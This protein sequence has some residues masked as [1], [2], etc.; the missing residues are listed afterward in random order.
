MRLSRSWCSSTILVMAGGGEWADCTRLKSPASSDH[1]QGARRGHHCLGQASQASRWGNRL[2][3]H[4]NLS[5]YIIQHYD[6]AQGANQ[7]ISFLAVMRFS[8]LPS[9]HSVSQESRG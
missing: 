5:T 4:L 9:L 7:L 1:G 6:L 2:L 8:Y 3:S